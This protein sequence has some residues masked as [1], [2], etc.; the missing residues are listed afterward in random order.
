MFQTALS[1][2]I[3]TFLFVNFVIQII[4]HNGDKWDHVVN[5]LAVCICLQS[6]FLLNMKISGAC[7]NPAIGIVHIAFTKLYYKHVFD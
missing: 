4:K 6:I 2:V 1:E 5:S 3:A 7:L